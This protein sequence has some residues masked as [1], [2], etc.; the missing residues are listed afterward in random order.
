MKDKEKQYKSP[1]LKSLHEVMSD[2]HEVG[3]IDDT[4]KR[5]FDDGCLKPAA[6]PARKPKKK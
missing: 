1:A 6:K 4:T 3:A 5:E 2:L